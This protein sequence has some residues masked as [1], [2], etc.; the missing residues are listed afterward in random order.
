[1]VA[2]D[3]NARQQCVKRTADEQ[4]KCLAVLFETVDKTNT[5]RLNEIFDK[6]GFPTS[7]LVGNGGV[8]DFMLLLQ[9]TTDESLRQKCLPAIKRAFKRKEISPMD[10]GNYVD[11]LR[12]HQGKPQIYGSNFE[13]KDGKLVM[14]PAIDPKNLDKRR[15][16]IGL[17]PIAEYA[18]GLKNLYH[19]EVV[20]PK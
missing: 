1:M 2:V 15:T 7:V 5:K 19:L 14:T 20:S 9:H 10:Y 12:V 3:Q 17:P 13:I 11:R 8:K 4:I 16:K 18:E 6:Y